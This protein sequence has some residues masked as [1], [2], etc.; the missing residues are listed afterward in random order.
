MKLPCPY[1]AQSL[2]LPDRF[3][4]KTTKCP[5]CQQSFMCPEIPED[6]NAPKKKAAPAAVAAAQHSDDVR[7]AGAEAMAVTPDDELALTSLTDERDHA[8]PPDP[9][10]LDNCPNCGAK[11]KKNSRECKKCHYNAIANA[12]IKPPPKR[13][14]NMHIDWQKIFLYM[15][16]VGVAYFGYFLYHGGWSKFSRTVNKEF[17]DAARGHVKAEDDA[18]MTRN[19]TRRE[20]E[21][22]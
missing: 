6:P 19:R 11:W 14:M 15:F 12:V 20:E 4:G 8:P 21:N 22:K 1:C 18:A 9:T 16:I 2:N 5:A 7:P 13:R 17:D 3:A 10:L